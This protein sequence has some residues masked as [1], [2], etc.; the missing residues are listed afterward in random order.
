M[1]KTIGYSRDNYNTSSGILDLHISW[2]NQP[3]LSTSD[4]HF[5]SLLTTG[6]IT[7]GGDL[8]VQGSTTISHSS[9]VEFNDNILTINAAE[10]GAGVTSNLSGIEVD[11]GTLTNYQ[12]VFQESTQLYKIGQVGNLQAVATREDTPL[13]NG[14]MTY[15]STLHR[16]DSVNNVTIPITFSAGVNSTSNSSGTVILS[17]GSGL[18]VTGD[19]YLDGVLKIKG[20]SSTYNTIHSDSSNNIEFISNANVLFN[21]ASG[22]SVQ[23]PTNVKLQLS[24]SNQT[25]V[26]DSTTLTVNNVVGNISLN[27]PYS[28]LLPIGSYLQWDSNNRIRYTGTDMTLNTSGNFNVNSKLI[29]TNSTIST[30][31]LTGTILSSGAIAVSLTSDSTSSTNGGSCTLGGGLAVNGSGYFGKQIIIA[32]QNVTAAQIA[33]QGINFR[34]LLRT[35]TTSSN[36]NV[37]FNSL[38]GGNINASG[39]IA[40][41]STL[42]IT[43]APAMTG[44]GSITNAYSL[45]INSGDLF[46]NGKLI[47]GNTT[48]SNSTSGSVLSSGGITSTNVTDASSSSIGGSGTFLGGGAFSK[49]LY[50]GNTLLI[51]DVNYTFNHT[52]NQGTN[53]RS[54]SRIINTSNLGDLTFNSLEGGTIMATGTIN[55]ASTLYISSPPTVSTGTVTNSYALLVGSGNTKLNGSLTVTGSQLISTDLTVNSVTN[56]NQTNINTNNGILQITGTN[57]ISSSV[58]GSTSFSSIGA[59]INSNAGVL[60]LSSSNTINIGTATSGTAINIGNS[61]TSETT[62][63]KN[64]TVGGNF[65][66]LGTTTTIN[67]VTTTLNDN[68]LVI[69]AAP[70]GTR[71][72]GVFFR[73]YQTP[74]DS[75]SGDAVSGIAEETGTFQSGS[76]TPNTLKLSVSA[77]SV[78]NYYRG[79]WVRVTSGSG[80]NQ[81]RRGKS[82]NGTTKILTLFDTADNTSTFVDGLDLTIAPSSGDTYSLFNFGYT[83]FY[84]DESSQEVRLAELPLVD[85][86]ATFPDPV[87]YLPLHIDSLSIN[88]GFQTNGDLIIDNTSSTALLVRKVGNTGDVLTVNTSTPSVGVQNPSNSGS[89]DILLNG[90]NAS[91]VSTTY[92][93]IESTIVDNS[94]LSNEL[95]FYVQSSSS[96]T[97]FLTLSGST[98]AINFESSVGVVNFLNTTSSSSSSSASVVFDGG[99]S[100]G[101][102]TNAVSSTNGGTFTTLGGGA[103]GKDLYVGG[104]LNVTGTFSAGMSSP[105]VTIFS[106]TNVSSSSVTTS[107]LNSN[108]N[109]RTLS[110][111]FRIT[112]T[113]GSLTTVVEFTIPSKVSNFSNLYDANLVCNGYYNDTTPV[114]VGNVFGYAVPSSTHARIS[115]TASN[116]TDVHTI[117]IQ[118]IYQS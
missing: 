53:F 64:L 46:T 3:L 65:T 26:S 67:S 20:N 58:S 80:I 15:N 113:S 92:S 116:N 47:I 111:T 50:V 71:D 114:S 104:N 87:K 81:V 101:N 28:V 33:G 109:Y 72:S 4:V 69:N 118:V 52:S 57:G 36:T 43:S 110:A 63:G 59:T 93:K 99:I 106:T 108:G 105:S 94:T 25:V 107:V 39:V 30:S 22:T 6:D 117:Q 82:Y 48:S 17:N 37:T 51:G 88:Q 41:A 10:T 112:P 18:A 21:Q 78:D 7:I 14:I 89:I 61:T 1:P 60:T 11:R 32:D 103:F 31:S 5:N 102:S 54:L 29:L 27:T 44:S 56:I 13:S 24:S 68:S 35:L 79:W 83:G 19:Q 45:Y 70:S 8:T 97:K 90:Y 73:R 100:I 9:I 55:N 12:S 16:L 74:N 34:S 96:L 91:N 98:N 38:E 49:S 76:S 42:Y 95:K 86:D 62:I 75:A 85:G 66:V 23:L 84:Y 40:Q 2:L 115:F 77:S